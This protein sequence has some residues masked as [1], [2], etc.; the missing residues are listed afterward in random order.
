MLATALL[1]LSLPVAA[2]PPGAPDLAA[3]GTGPGVRLEVSGREAGPVTL[4]DG[5]R[6][7]AVLPAG[8][9]PASFETNAS[10]THTFVARRGAEASEPIVVDAASG[11]L[12][13]AT[14][15]ARAPGGGTATAGVAVTVVIPAGAL[16]VTAPCSRVGRTPVVTVTDTRAGELGFVVT[17]SAD[18]PTRL[19]RAW[20]QQVQGNA[21]PA[22]EVRTAHAAALRPGR[23]LRVAAL[24]AGTS[25]GSVRVGVRLADVAR[26]T[27]TV[28]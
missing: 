21:L 10:G 27:W 16:T 26:L 14:A 12:E 19:V 3:V 18:R 23:A 2:P 6:Q 9:G 15:A 11:V 13:A 28:L 5:E 22:V 25:L 4:W 8:Q 1:L 7:V 20:S 24:P 17:V